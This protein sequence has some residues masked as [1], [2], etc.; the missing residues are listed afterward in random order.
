MVS[1]RNFAGKAQMKARAVEHLASLP[2]FS[3]Q[4]LQV[5]FSYIL[6]P[7]CQFVVSQNIVTMIFPHEIIIIII[8]T[9]HCV[10]LQLSTIA[11]KY[12]PGKCICS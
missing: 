3:P 10:T 8:I 1:I 6:I 4:S 11:L 12:L 7:K 5:C 2:L 9:F